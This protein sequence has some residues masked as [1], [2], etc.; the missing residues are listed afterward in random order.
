M[1]IYELVGIRDSD[2]ET[3]ATQAEQDLCKLTYDAFEH[4]VKADYQKAKSLYQAILEKYDDQLSRVMIEK[5]QL[6]LGVYMDF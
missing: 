2:A 5:C 6:K 3:I 1:L 4:Y